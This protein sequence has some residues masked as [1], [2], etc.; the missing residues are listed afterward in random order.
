MNIISIKQLLCALMALCLSVWASADTYTY[1]KLNRL[2][3]ISFSNG[4]G[5]AYTYDP[6]GNILSIA[7][8]MPNAGTPVCTLSTSP[9]SLAAGDLTLTASCTPAATSY[10]WT[11]G[12]CAGNTTSQCTLTPS[13]TTNY[14][15]AGINSFGTGMAVSA[16]VTATR[17]GS[18]C[19]SL[20]VQTSSSGWSSHTCHNAAG[21]TSTMA[22]ST[23]VS[24]TAAEINT[25]AAAAAAPAGAT[26]PVAGP[27]VCTLHASPLVLSAG[28]SATLTASCT[29]AATSYVWSNSGFDASTGIGTVSPVKPTRYSVMGINSAGS[30]AAATA[31][32]YVCNTPPSEN[33]PGLMLADSRASS[34]EP[35]PVGI[36]SDTIDGGPGFNPVIYQCNHSSFTV[37]KTTAGWAVS[38]PAE[39]LDTPANAE[40][41]ELG[42]PTLALDISGHAGQVYRLYQAAFDRIPDNAGL[43]YWIGRMQAGLTLE[44]VAAG[45]V[46]SPEFQALY[47]SH[48]D[49]AEFLTRLYQNVLHRTP[50]QAGYDWWLGQLNAGR[51]DKITALASFSESPENQA[52]V[53]GAILN[54]LDLLN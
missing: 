43:K 21:P 31:A 40:R 19:S 18:T 51:Y 34:S 15:V 44:Q 54:G 3:A 10:K 26:A 2:T 27:P 28:A 6:A 50:D 52:R 46:D 13:A 23:T 24:H 41:I 16:T 30:G 48:P 4:G 37:T 36:S 12:T 14:T 33:Y 17:T 1:D 9:A 47:G 22:P 42:R 11:G 5:Q 38:A 45:F 8:L 49:N 35:L 53:L 20:T 29:P 7:T 32:V 39:G 25:A